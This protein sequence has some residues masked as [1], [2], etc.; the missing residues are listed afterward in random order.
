M[1][2]GEDKLYFWYTVELQIEKP[3]PKKVVELRTNIR[4][5]VV[6]EIELANPMK[7]LDA[8]FDVLIKGSG[9]RGPAYFEVGPGQSRTY[10]LYF[11]P[12]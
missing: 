11:Q 12:L 1:G 8:N 5:A 3:P 2:G 10:K 9:L 4:N 7:T 6:F